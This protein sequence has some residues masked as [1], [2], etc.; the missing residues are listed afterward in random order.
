I[1][2]SAMIRSPMQFSRA[3]P[4]PACRR[5]SYTHNHAIGTSPK[6]AMPISARS[7]SRKL[8]FEK[9]VDNEERIAAN[10]FGKTHESG[11]AVHV[12]VLHDP[13][14]PGPQHLDHAVEQCLL[15][16]SGAR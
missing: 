12:V 6:V 8:G 4:I 2:V 15:C 13:H 16:Q 7:P 10:D 5:S 11:I 9:S 3:G 1:E 14:R